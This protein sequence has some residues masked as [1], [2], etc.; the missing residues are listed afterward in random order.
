MIQKTGDTPR[1]LRVAERLER[2]LEALIRDR[3]LKPGARLPSERALAL[4]FGAS[5]ASLREAVR[6]LATRGLIEI[7]PNG[8]FVAPLS[9]AAPPPTAQSW[10][11]AS[12]RAPLSTL[13]ADHPGYGQDLMEVRVGLEG[14]AAYH[15]ALRADR[16]AKA[17]ILARLEELEAHDG[18]VDAAEHARLDAAFHLAI[19]QSSNNAI[20]YHVM[21]SLFGLLQ[22]TIRQTLEKIYMT[23][24]TAENLGEQHREIYDAIVAGD[25]EAARRAT[26][27]HLAFITGSLRE[28]DEDR[29]RKARA[30]AMQIHIED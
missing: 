16:T 6:Q 15:A 22:S 25:A 19:A 26:E 5:R 7:R 2:D 12:I 30:Q 17:L 23:P 11:D 20:L 10:A 24:R 28:V 13:V 9:Q 21:S 29:A 14:T 1:T 27:G 4:D 8:I 3:D 18:T